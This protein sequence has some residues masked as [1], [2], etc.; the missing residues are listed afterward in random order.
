MLAQHYHDYEIILTNDGSTDGS[1]AIC[2][3][4][5]AKDARIRYYS[6]QN[7]GLLLT[8]R[9]AI[10][11]AKGEY[12]LFLDSDDYWAPNLLETVAA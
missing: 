4:Y 2:E 6:K 8:R 1:P 11:L 10:R 5:A 12:V 7:E 3:A 9:Y